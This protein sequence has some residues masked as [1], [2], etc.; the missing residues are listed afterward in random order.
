MEI[1]NTEMINFCGFPVRRDR[2][3]NMYCATD[4]AKIAQTYAEI[5]V[6]L[7]QFMNSD[8]FNRIVKDLHKDKPLIRKGRGCKSA[9]WVTR[10]LLIYIG[11]NIDRGFSAKFCSNVVKALK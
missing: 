5:P 7:S 6:N 2:D 1:K 8:K 4:L 3:H 10:E 9:T 11:C